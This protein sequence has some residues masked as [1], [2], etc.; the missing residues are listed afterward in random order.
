M[1]YNSKTYKVLRKLPEFFAKEE[2]TNNY[3]FIN[4]FDEDLEFM[5]E[6]ILNMKKACQVETAVGK[7]L[8]DIGEIFVLSRNPGESDNAYRSRIIGF[9]PGYAGGGTVWSIRQKVERITGI[10]PDKIQITDFSDGLVSAPLKFRVNADVG[11]DADLGTLQSVLEFAK[12]AGTYML[13]DL[14]SKETDIYEIYSESVSFNLEK[15]YFT[16]DVS[17]PDYYDELL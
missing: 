10:S 12:A 14:T 5:Q 7:E 1:D 4:S 6:Q 9:W 2:D 15:L 8:D 3:K 17:I 16:P 13:F 11:F